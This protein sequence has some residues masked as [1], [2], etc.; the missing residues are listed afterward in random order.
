M[1]STKPTAARRQR[2][3]V[4]TDAR[5][6]KPAILQPPLPQVWVCGVRLARDWYDRH[7]AVRDYLSKRF[8]RTPFML[9]CTLTIFNWLRLRPYMKVQEV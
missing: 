7:L 9:H 8:G 5:Q 3:A 1:L 6:P 2:V 4:L